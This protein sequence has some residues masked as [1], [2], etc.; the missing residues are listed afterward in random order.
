MRP[1]LFGI[2]LNK[3]GTKSFG[4]ACRILGFL[5]ASFNP[6]LMIAYHR[7]NI[8]TILHYAAAYES[9]EDWPWPLVYRQLHERF[10]GAR[11]V[12]TVRA[13]PA[14]WFASLRR[15]AARTGPTLYREIAYGHAMPDRHR[16]R[17]VAVYERHN[18]EVRR[19]FRD[20][21]GAMV[22][23]CWERGDGWAV[24][25]RFLGMPMPEVPFPHLG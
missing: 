2:G 14:V 5:H 25:C 1:K 8:E 11:F 24:L 23:L 6:E 9:F 18:A 17:H 10:P 22:E 12:L 15:H 19:Y 13:N 4:E 3:T 7:R 16:A 21:P 20:Y